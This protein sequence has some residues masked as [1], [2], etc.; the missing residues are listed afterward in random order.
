[1]FYDN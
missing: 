1:M